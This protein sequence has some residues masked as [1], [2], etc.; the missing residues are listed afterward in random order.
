MNKTRFCKIRNLFEVI[1]FVCLSLQIRG[2]QAQTARFTIHMENVP[3]EQVVNE[4]EK[5]S[6]YL[7]LFNKDIDSRRI[8]VS[9]DAENQTITQIFPGLFEGTGLDY[10]IEGMLIFVT[11]KTNISGDPV[12][13]SGKV[14]DPQGQ[15]IVGASVI[16]R[17]TTVGV[18]TDAAGRFKLEV[19]APVSSRVLEI[20][21]LGYETARVAVGSRTR[22]D[23]TLRE[24]ASEIEQVV[25]TALGIKR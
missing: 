19:P 7:F 18:S 2:A 1:L 3:M 9:V 24:A 23:V 14:V 12:T 13:V 20:S 17:G 25:V 5:Q 6:R 11:K 16:V 22:F 8:I 10:T 4:I 21:Y 15:P